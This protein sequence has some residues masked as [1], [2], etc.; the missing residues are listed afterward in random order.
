MELMELA[1]DNISDEDICKDIGRILNSGHGA[2]NEGQLNSKSITQIFQVIEKHIKSA[3]I[4]SDFLGFILFLATR[5]NKELRGRVQKEA[6][7][8][9]LYSVLENLGICG[10]KQIAFV[11]LSIISSNTHI[12]HLRH[13]S[14]FFFVM[15]C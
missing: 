9:I 2:L 4:C 5:H 13:S 14:Y 3:D 11:T 10:Y 15:T 6:V 7:K 12:H 1:S 8:K